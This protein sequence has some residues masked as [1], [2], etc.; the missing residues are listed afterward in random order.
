[1]ISSISIQTSLSSNGNLVKTSLKIAMSN[2]SIIWM[3]ALQILERKKSLNLRF[4][5]FLAKV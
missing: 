3:M 5:K 1:M 4:K 2:M